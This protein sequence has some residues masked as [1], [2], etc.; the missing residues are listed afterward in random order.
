MRGERTTAREE[1]AVFGWHDSKA[2]GAGHEL[3]PSE[4]RKTRKQAGQEKQ[5]LTK[6]VKTGGGR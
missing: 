4:K 3:I 5:G 1:K 2:G 6:Q